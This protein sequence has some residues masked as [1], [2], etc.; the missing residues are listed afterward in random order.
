MKTLL[1]A[2]AVSLP[3]GAGLFADD[4][5][6]VERC[7]VE[8]HDTRQKTEAL[9]AELE[10]LKSELLQLKTDHPDVSDVDTSSGAEE[11]DLK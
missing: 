1:I 8:L 4:F 10:Q 2:V 11:L 9:Q 7:F 5:G 6:I 3:F